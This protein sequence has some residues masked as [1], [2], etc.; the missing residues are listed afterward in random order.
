MTYKRLKLLSYKFDVHRCLNDPAEIEGTQDDPRDFSTVMKVDTH[1]HLSAAMTSKHLLE[2][3][4]DKAENHGEDV[5]ALSKDGQPETLTKVFSKL[6]IDLVRFNLNVLD[7][8]ADNTFERFDN[9]NAKYS[10]MG[11]SQLRDVFLKSENGVLGGRY[12]AELTNQLLEKMERSQ[13]TAAEYRISIYGLKAGEWDS[14]A[15]WAKKFNVYS[16]HLR[17]LVQIPRIFFIFR[18]HGT[19][20]N[21]EQMLDNIFRPLFE[22]SLNP[23]SHPDLHVFLQHVSGFDSVDD[24]SRS[25]RQFDVECSKILPGAWSSTENPPYAYYSWYFWANIASLNQLRQQRGLKTF[26]FR[27]HCGES[28]SVDHLASAF[29]LARHINHGINLA[30]TTPLQYLYYLAQI[31]LAVSPLSNNSLFLDYNNNPFKKFFCRGL[32]VSLSTDDP[33]QFHYTEEPLL[34]EYS[35]CGQR[36]KMS[37]IDLSEIARMSVLQSGFEHRIKT[38][39]LGPRYLLAG[40]SGN[41]VSFSNVPNLRLQFRSDTLNQEVSLINKLASSTPL[42]KANSSLFTRISINEPHSASEKI[43]QD[44]L[45]ACLNLSGALALI[46][47]YHPTREHNVSPRDTSCIIRLENGVHSVYETQSVASKL[48]AAVDPMEPNADYAVFCR[49]VARMVDVLSDGATASFSFTR[50]TLL[51]CIFGMHTLMNSDIE[52]QAMKHVPKDFSHLSKVDGYIRAS[53]GMLAKHLLRFIRAKLD[54]NP[55]IPLKEG[56][57]IPLRDLFDQLGLPLSNL[58][59]DNL[60]VKAENT[61]MRLDAFQSKNNP[62]GNSVLRSLFLDVFNVIDGSFFGEITKQLIDSRT[63]ADPHVLHEFRIALPGRTP[64]DWNTLARWLIK[65]E[66]LVDNVRWVIELPLPYESFVAEGSVSSFSDVLASIFGP[67]FLATKDPASS[68]DL[69]RVLDYISGFDVPYSKSDY[70]SNLTNLPMPRLWIKESRPPFAYLIFFIQ[71]NL[72]SLNTFRASKC[73]STFQL[74]S[75]IDIDAP[76]YDRAALLLL[77][78]LVHHADIV[79]RGRPT[80]S[81]LMYLARIGAVMSP[82][83]SN[84]LALNYQESPF[85]KSFQRGLLV[86]LGTDS[87]LQLHSM[88]DPLLEE[89]AIASQIFRLSACDLSEICMN[90]VLSSGFPHQVKQ[91]ILGDAYLSAQDPLLCSVPS[92]RT[93]FRQAAWHAEIDRLG[94]ICAAKP[95]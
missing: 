22:V 69:T 14:L 54:E 67:L 48:F 81:Y 65:H 15:C 42:P 56:Q 59:L 93:T 47:S 58:T 72:K 63:K 34:E 27:P 39:W 78:D 66:L 82:L 44:Q 33:L 7:T 57:N 87:P 55:P 51:E 80:T 19:L 5:V 29:L 4:K 92:V 11:M 40:P 12:Y 46:R 10:P 68:P 77:T 53:T 28:G 62:F 37:D 76:Y 85:S 89:F 21:F 24:E 26:D 38:E 25:E 13:F 2:F 83:S 73:M 32:N 31:G 17:W 41:E 20:Q 64:S 16:K 70:L 60:N 9:F 75:A 50:L 95:L 1:I 74:S 79:T 30:K 45:K 91:R 84:A 88:D 61:F 35:V 86:S 43:M 23:E 94:R 49:D 36:W 90:S 6:G 52:K 18:T 3:I 8:R 71:A